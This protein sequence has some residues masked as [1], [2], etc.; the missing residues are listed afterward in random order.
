MKYQGPGLKDVQAACPSKLTSFLSQILYIILVPDNHSFTHTSTLQHLR[1][2]IVVEGDGSL[3]CTL[4]KLLK[5]EESTH[6]L[7]ALG[8]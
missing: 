7:L 5:W 1:S 4:T 8:N 6:V 2:C 3:S